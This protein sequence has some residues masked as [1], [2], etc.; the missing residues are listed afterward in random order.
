MDAQHPDDVFNTPGNRLPGTYSTASNNLA[1]VVKHLGHFQSVLESLQVQVEQG[2]QAL[3]ESQDRYAD[4]HAL[5][6]DALS[7]IFQLEYT[8][9]NIQENQGALPSS[10][11]RP[12]RLE[13]PGTFNGKTSSYKNWRARLL[14]YLQG[15]GQA[16]PRP[17][18]KILY[19]ATNLLD[20]A[21]QWYQS[22]VTDYP[23]IDTEAYYVAFFTAM[24]TQYGD[25]HEQSRAMDALVSIKQGANESFGE[26]FSRFD[27]V[28][29]Q[30]QAQDGVTMMTLRQAVHPKIREAL[31]CAM[32]Y[33][34]NDL[35]SVLAKT[36]AIAYAFEGNRVAQG[37]SG[38]NFRNQYQRN[39]Q[40]GPSC[41]LPGHV[42]HTD[43]QCMAQHPELRPAGWAPRPIRPPPLV[44]PAGP[45]RVGAVVGDVRKDGPEDFPPALGQ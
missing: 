44:V 14:I 34:R 43:A 18:N 28:R 15:A 10:T 24:D 29:R 45:R 7:R 22:H 30:A 5:Y 20:G 2:Q 26:F 3:T 35:A 37:P 38:H 36:R 17:I 23:L 21:L 31:T 19:A 32:D 9:R 4:I 39:G 13:G 33:D 16:Y 6:Q 11:P 12:G 42:G 1:D 27:I 41:K 25:P 8:I 40:P